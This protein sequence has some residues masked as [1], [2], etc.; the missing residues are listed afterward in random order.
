MSETYIDNSI[1]TQGADGAIC[2]HLLEGERGLVLM[3]VT[4][5]DLFLFVTM[6]VAVITLVK[7][8]DKHN[9]K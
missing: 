5:S 4:Y 7:N 3:Y 1:L 6:L 8:N 9:K 2:S